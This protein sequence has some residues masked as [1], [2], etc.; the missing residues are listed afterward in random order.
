[1]PSP[2]VTVVIPTLS[3]GDALWECVRSLQNQSCRNFSIV[4]VDNSGEHRVN[5]TWPSDLPNT[6]VTTLH[7]GANLGY[8][9][10][11]NLAARSH[12]ADF[13]AVINDDAAAHPL[14]LQS[15]LDMFAQH[16]EAGSAASQVRLAGPADSLDSAGMAIAADGTTKQRGH[17]QSPSLFNEPAEVLLPSG[18]AAIYRAETFT[19]TGG[20][21]DDFFLYCEDSDLGLRARWAGWT[22]RYVPAAIVHHRY[23]HSAGRASRLKAFYV[24]RNRLRLIVKNFPAP[25]IARALFAT[26]LRYLY[27]FLAMRRGHGA[28]AQFQRDGQSAWTLVSCVLSAHFELVRSLPRLWRQRRSIRATAKISAASF[29]ATLDR[30][31]ISLQQ[32]AEL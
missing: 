11:V 23:S 6:A 24:E 8:G 18:S 28:A 32:V 25:R 16:P 19:Q 9:S 7:P 1:M 26:P 12:P 13:I 30:H 17:L 29:A 3:A 10:A 21:D 27:H 2:R 20:F 22:C 4:I 15:L 31:S 14:W 5:N